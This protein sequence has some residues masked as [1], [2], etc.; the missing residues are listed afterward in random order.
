MQLLHQLQ[1]L[2]VVVVHLPVAADQRLPRLAHSDG[3]PAQRPQA[4]EVAL[5][6]ELE[7]GTT[8]GADVVDS[9]GQA[10]LGNGRG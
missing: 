7:A 1:R 4:G 8:T 10:E 5:L 6:E 9:V 2:E 3:L